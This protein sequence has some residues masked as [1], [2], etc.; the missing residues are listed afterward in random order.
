MQQSA[1]TEPESVAERGSISGVQSEQLGRKCVAAERLVGAVPWLLEPIW[2]TGERG[3]RL[4][5]SGTVFLRIIAAV[6]SMISLLS[7]VQPYLFVPYLWI[8]STRYFA[9]VYEFFGRLGF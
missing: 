6:M 7:I 5:I 4:T 2:R 9:D 3:K 8:K 1:A